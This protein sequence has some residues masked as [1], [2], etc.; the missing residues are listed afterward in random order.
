MEIAK[1]QITTVHMSDITE[2]HG[3]NFTS[4]S[5]LSIMTSYSNKIE[6][7]S[8]RRLISF[9]VRVFSSSKITIHKSIPKRSCPNC[10]SVIL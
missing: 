1:N 3:Q 10:Q 4:Q 8:V 6:S 2:G 7:S 9:S 5:L